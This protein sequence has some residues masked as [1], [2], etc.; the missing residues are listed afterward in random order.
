MT[1]ELPRAKD[2]SELL[3][4]KNP[5]ADARL[6]AAVTRGGTDKTRIPPGKRASTPQGPAPKGATK[7]KGISRNGQKTT[8]GVNAR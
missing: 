2:R 1:D 5:I 4:G 3:N 8:R 6:M 7:R